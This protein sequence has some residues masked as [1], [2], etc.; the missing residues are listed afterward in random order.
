[1]RPFCECAGSYAVYVGRSY[2]DLPL[3]TSQTAIFGFLAETDFFKLKTI[4]LYI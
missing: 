4:Y 2:I 1:M 3:L